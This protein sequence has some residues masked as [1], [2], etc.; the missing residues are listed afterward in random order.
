M[1]STDQSR[2]TV[3]GRHL[4]GRIGCVLLLLFVVLLAPTASA[5]TSVFSDS[6]T[7]WQPDC[8][9]LSYF[10]LLAGTSSDTLKLNPDWT[11]HSGIAVPSTSNLD[12]GSGAVTAD[13]LI[14]FASP[15]VYDSTNCNATGSTNYC[16]TGTL[17]GTTPSN[18][19]AARV[20]S[21]VTQLN[22]ILNV[23]STSTFNTGNGTVTALP[24]STS[25]ELNITT[26]LSGGTLK[27]FRNTSAYTTNGT[28]TLGCGLTACDNN[29][30]VVIKLTGG[31][32]AINHDLVLNDGLTPDQVIFYI[33]SNNLNITPTAAATT[34][35][36]SFFVGAGAATVVGT[37]GS[38]DPVTM[39]GRLYNGNG[40]ITLNDKGT[41]A[42]QIWSDQG[43]SEIPEPGTWALMGCGLAAMVCIARQRKRR[44]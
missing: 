39:Y 5:N 15:V 10:G 40:N 25:G 7:C 21:A 26:G 4:L 44:T 13:G 29:M 33:P 34:V 20:N 24:T 30:L 18:T 12:R 19:N 32:T 1:G 16:G 9:A 17:S 3:C 22:S 27:I 14:D 28:I 2:G 43:I 36:G 11:I 37:T 23:L 31:N 41:S 38:A 35:R 42:Q 6:R 8:Q